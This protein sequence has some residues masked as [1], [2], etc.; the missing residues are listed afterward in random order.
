MTGLQPEGFADRHEQ[1]AAEDAM[2]A[3]LPPGH[4]EALIAGS[5]GFR[6]QIA[7]VVARAFG[8]DFEA[9]PEWMKLMYLSDADRALSP[10]SHAAVPAGD[11]ATPDGGREDVRERAASVLLTHRRV[12][13]ASDGITCA[14]GWSGPWLSRHQADAVMAEVVDPLL[15]TIA[16]VEALYGEASDM[17]TGVLRLAAIRRALDACRG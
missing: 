6:V 10:P 3:L 7:R 5:Q 11:G 12:G 4:P 1:A 14:C 13:E 9:A 2:R 15:A 8:N 17:G 16:R